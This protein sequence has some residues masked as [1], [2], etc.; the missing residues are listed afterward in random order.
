MTVIATWKGDTQKA[1][2]L[3]D[4]AS[5]PSILAPGRNDPPPGFF[6]GDLS[7]DWRLRHYVDDRDPNS[8]WFFVHDGKADGAGYFV[9]YR[10]DSRRRIGSSDSR[11][12]PPEPV[13]KGDKFPVRRFLRV[14]ELVLELSA[15]FDL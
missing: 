5:G 1:P 4:R 13:P 6:T 3:K 14:G 8:N 7:W 10:R 9:G 12:S 2:E 11:G 15:N